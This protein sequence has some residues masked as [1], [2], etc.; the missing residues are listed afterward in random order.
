MDDTATLRT[1]LTLAGF[2]PDDLRWLDG[3]GWRIDQTPAIENEAQRQAYE[4]REAAIAASAAH[5]TYAERGASP[6]GRLAAMI[7]ARLAD[8]RERGGDDEE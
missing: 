3:F 5:L 7:G 4:R 6:E 1:A 8:W 2:S